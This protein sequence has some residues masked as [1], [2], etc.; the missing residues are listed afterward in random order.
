MIEE[1]RPRK[2]GGGICDLTILSFIRKHGFPWSSGGTRKDIQ[3][4]LCL[5]MRNFIYAAYF[6]TPLERQDYNTFKY[7]K[8]NAL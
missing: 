8:Y 7:S 3:I 5:L 6:P 4:N 1:E 2:E